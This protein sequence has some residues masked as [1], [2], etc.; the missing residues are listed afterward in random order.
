MKIKQYP[1]YIVWLI[2][3][4]S[5]LQPSYAIQIEFDY[6]FDTQ[7]FFTDLVTGD[8]IQERRARLKQA[9]SFYS[10]FTDK[11]TAIQPLSGNSWSVN[12]GHPGLLGS[13]VTLTN[14]PVADNSLRV[15]VGGSTSF[16]GV[17]GFAGT[18]WELSSTGSQSFN[19]NVITR[20]Q[21]KTTGKNASDYATWGGKH[22]V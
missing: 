8:P 12:I 20:G 22:L 17:L 4:S 7:G 3:L 11:L 21:K 10:G 18:G 2:T 15:F 19:N 16:A 1:I 6:R 9:A 13:S 5:L 14:V